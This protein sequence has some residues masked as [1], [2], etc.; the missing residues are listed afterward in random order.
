MWNGH[1]KKLFASCRAGI[2]KSQDYGQVC[3]SCHKWHVTSKVEPKVLCRSVLVPSE[4]STSDPTFLLLLSSLLS[5]GQ[6]WQLHPQLLLECNYFT[7]KTSKTAPYPNLPKC[8]P[9]RFIANEEYGQSAGEQ[10]GL[11]FSSC[12]NSISFPRSEKSSQCRDSHHA[13]SLFFL[14]PFCNFYSGQ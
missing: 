12:H 3:N 10:E 2:G 13:H 9:S 4:A 5:L 1:S 7:Q 8:F 14:L 6:G 11:W